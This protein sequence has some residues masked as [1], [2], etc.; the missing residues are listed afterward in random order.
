MNLKRIAVYVILYPKGISLI[1][2]DAAHRLIRLY[3]PG[4]QSMRIGAGHLIPNA[5]L[6][7]N[8]VDA[9]LFYAFNQ[10]LPRTAPVMLSAR[11]ACILFLIQKLLYIKDLFPFKH[12]INRTAYFMGHNRQCFGFAVFSLKLLLVLFDLRYFSKHQYRCL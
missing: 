8:A 7:V 4:V 6:T 9:W 1:E 10:A 2:A 3:R 5:Q 12:V 11:P